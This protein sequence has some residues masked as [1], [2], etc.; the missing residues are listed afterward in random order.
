MRIAFDNEA[1]AAGKVAAGDVRSVLGSSEATRGWVE[2][3][4]LVVGEILGEIWGAGGAGEENV[5]EWAGVLGAF[6]AILKVIHPQPYLHSLL[7][8]DDGAA[9]PFELTRA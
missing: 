4:E 6:K 3:N 9:P 7:D 2:A 1:T 5:L 8:N